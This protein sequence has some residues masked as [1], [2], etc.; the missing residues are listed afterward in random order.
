MLSGTLNLKLLLRKYSSGI[1]VTWGLVLLENCLLALIPLFIGFSI[2]DLLAGVTDQLMVLFMV[3]VLLTIIAVLRRIYDTRMYGAIK[4]ALGL[5]LDQRNTM[6]NISIRSARLDMSRE[7]VCFLEDGVPELITGLTQI[8]ISLVILASFSSILAANAAGMILI[9]VILYGFFHHSFLRLNQA[10]N[11][12]TERQVALL[13]LGFKTSLHKHLSLLFRWEVKLSDRE[14]I[15]YGLIFLVVTGFIVANL[16]AATAM[17][18]ISAGT[19]F[20]IVTYSWEFVQAA[21]VL[22]IT[23]Q[24]LTRLQEIT[25]RINQTDSSKAQ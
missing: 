14:A 17:P 2:D 21:L 9:M 24:G 22:P 13:A 7:L 6:L 5:E 10:L 1:A 4:V 19:I 16:W 12:Q 3:M 15:L 25:C 18:E 23:L 8:I 11:N 20:T